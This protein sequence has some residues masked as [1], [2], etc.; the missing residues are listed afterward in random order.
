[1]DE[2]ERQYW[3]RK[4]KKQDAEFIRQALDHIIDAR[5]NLGQRGYSTDDEIMR[6]LQSMIDRMWRLSEKLEYGEPEETDAEHRLTNTPDV[7]P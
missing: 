2:H 1:M 5:I 7:Y 4:S 3:L 6:E